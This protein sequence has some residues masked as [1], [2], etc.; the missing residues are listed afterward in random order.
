ML[1]LLLKADSSDLIGTEPTLQ[2]LILQKSSLA[3]D[4]IMMFLVNLPRKYFIVS[5]ISL[6]RQEG[7][8]LA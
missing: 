8:I 4:S 5:T 3:V 1:E 2:T 6:R 7:L